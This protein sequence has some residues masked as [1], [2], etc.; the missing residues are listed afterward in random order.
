[1]QEHAHD[2][3]RARA[4]THT[5][6]NEIRPACTLTR[7]HKKK[8]VLL[9]AFSR[10]LWFRKCASMLRNST[11]PVLLGA[12]AKLRKATLSFVTFFCLSAWNSSASTRG[13]LMKLDI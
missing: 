1:M 12:F 9:I 5:H 2:I 11:L 7:V 10:Q 8:Y 4:H 13:I 6:T 3:A